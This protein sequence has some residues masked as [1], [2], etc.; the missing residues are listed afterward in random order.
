MIDRG[1][2]LRLAMGGASSITDD[3][4]A[5]L[6]RVYLAWLD[7]SAASEQRLRDAME[8]RKPNCSADYQKGFTDGYV[9]SQH[10]PE[11][12]EG[13]LKKIQRRLGIVG[14]SYSEIADQ[15]CKRLDG[16]E[17]IIDRQRSGK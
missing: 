1:R 12:R 4:L 14:A 8:G 2:V 13:A 9:A 5:E 7:A 3:E 6:C 16:C 17:A 11:T 10:M 15:V